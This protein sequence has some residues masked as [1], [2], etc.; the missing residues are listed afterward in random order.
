M[1]YKCRYFL[2]FSNK[3]VVD[4]ITGNNVALSGRRF[5]EIIRTLLSKWYYKY[6]LFFLK[7]NSIILIIKK[8]I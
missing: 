1:S 5:H 2:N 7:Y 3:I 8:G 4:G 6:V